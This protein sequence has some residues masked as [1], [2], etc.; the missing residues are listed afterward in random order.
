VCAI[1]V[2]GLSFCTRFLA[3]SVSGVAFFIIV[4]SFHPEREREKRFMGGLVH[5]ILN[6]L[7]LETK[8]SRPLKEDI[9]D[10]ITLFVKR[11]NKYELVQNSFAS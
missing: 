8:R 10:S 4:S 6:C 7:S 2:A 3:T 1:V 11:Y 5:F 9:Y